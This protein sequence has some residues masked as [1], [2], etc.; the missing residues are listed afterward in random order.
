MAL[1]A[2]LLL[3]LPPGWC[4]TPTA[5]ATESHDAPP[6][7][8]PVHPCGACCPGGASVPTDHPTPNDENIPERAPAAPEKAGN[9]CCTVQTSARPDDT[10]RP[11]PAAP[12]GFAV[13][14]ASPVFAAVDDLAPSFLPP[15]SVP[16]HVLHCVWS[17]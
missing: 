6:A 13:T 5:E 17:C 3:A 4:C 8:A 15:P 10:E 1:S 14:L 11:L 16:I 9:C 7:E 2:G 12:A